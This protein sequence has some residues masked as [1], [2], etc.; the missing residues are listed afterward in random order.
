MTVD[1]RGEQSDLA[2]EVDLILQAVP[3]DD[4][5]A[6][7]VDPLIRSILHAEGRGGAWGVAIVL[8][9]DAE[10]RQLHDRFMGIDT[11]TDVMT[12]PADHSSELHGGDVIVSVDRARAQATEARHSEA[13]E[14]WFLIAHGV[15]HLCGWRDDDDDLRSRMHARQTE[16]LARFVDQ[17]GSDSTR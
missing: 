9:S 12:F 13:D 7:E 10:L 11:E 2:L 8:T 5:A 16:L 4:F 1:Q 15:L 6:A 14:I 3:P 17:A